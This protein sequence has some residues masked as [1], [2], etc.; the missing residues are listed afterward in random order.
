MLSGAE[1]RS[2]DPQGTSR[3]D[4]PLESHSLRDIIKR[5]R[6]G[7]PTRAKQDELDRRKRRRADGESATPTQSPVQNARALPHDTTLH[8][9]SQQPEPEEVILGSID[10]DGQPIPSPAP[11]KD[12]AKKQPP[13]SLASSLLSSLKAS[14]ALPEPQPPPTQVDLSAP[15]VQFVNGKIVI[16]KS[17]LVITAGPEPDALEEFSLIR[18][19]ASHLTS[20]TYS[21][22]VPTERWSKLDT[23][24]F[25]QVIL[26]I[27]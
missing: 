2:P 13:P 17:S 27:S 8:L 12:Q 1:P 19:G 26:V 20:A 15:Q 21:N 4:P 14:S 10:D 16:D 7:K 18:E 22:R 5:A 3:P 23:E 6:Q 9:G 11:S 24:R 25:Y